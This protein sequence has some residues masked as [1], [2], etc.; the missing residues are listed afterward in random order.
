MGRVRPMALSLPTLIYKGTSTNKK[1]L[2]M[3]LIIEN[4]YALM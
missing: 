3:R 4:N 2:Y 1:Q